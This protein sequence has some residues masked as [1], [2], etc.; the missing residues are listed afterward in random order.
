MVERGLLTP[1]QAEE[2]QKRGGDPAESTV[3]SLPAAPGAGAPGHLTPPTPATGRSDSGVLFSCPPCGKVY[4]LP[5]GN[6]ASPPVCPECRGALKPVQLGSLIVNAAPAPAAPEGQ[7]FGR[8]LLKRELG[9]GGMGVVYEAWDPVLGRPVALKMLSGSGGDLDA[10]AVERLLREA[11]AAAKLRHPAIVGIHDVGQAEGR[12]YF[13]MDL[14]DGTGLDAL[15]ARPDW[16]ETLPLRRRVEIVADVADALG[17]AHA[18]GIIHRDVKPSNILLDWRGTVMLLDF[19]L[20][21]DASV[22]TEALTRTGVL[23][24]TPHYMSPE[25]ASRSARAAGPGSDVFSLGVVFY[26]LLTAELPF[27]G[28][29]VQVLL[30]IVQGEPER[31]SKRDPAVPR[32]LETICLKCLEKDPAQRYPD[33]ETL[34]EDL[35][36]WLA[37]EPIAARPVGWGRRLWRRLTRAVPAPAQ[38]DVRRAEEEKSR[39]IEHARAQ[40]EAMKLLEQAR[41]ALDRATQYLYDREAGYEE[42]TRRVDAAQA[43]IEQ[44]LGKCG[45]L[46]LGH[47]LLGRAW[48]LKGLDDRAEGCWRE[49]LRLDPDFGPA[50]YQLGR[51]LVERAYTWPL[52][53]LPEERAAHASEAQRWA[54]EA[55]EEFQRALTLGSGF[56]D[57][58]LKLLAAAMVAFT[59][60]DRA[61][62]ARMCRSGITD[63]PGAEGREEFHWLLGVCTTGEERGRELDKA[64]E[65]RPKY[66]LARFFR[67]SHRW[68]SGD[69][70]GARVDFDETIRI[71]PHF[72]AAR[73]NRGFFLYRS[74]DAAGALRDLDEAVRLSPDSAVAWNNRGLAKS[75]LGDKAGAR[76]D[77]ESALRIKP[78]YAAALVNRAGC[79]R[80]D[81]DLDGAL[82]DAT[83]AI[84]SDPKCGP[85]WT[86]RGLAR[87]E[88]GDLTGALSDYEESIRLNPRSAI[89]WNNRGNVKSALRDWAGALADY[90]EA[91]KLNPKFHSAHA[92][93][94]EVL[95]KMGDPD[96]ALAAGER[97]LAI[98]PNHAFSFAVRGT[99]KARKGDV[100]GALADLDRALALDSVD[101]ETLLERALLRE[102]LGR[103][104]EGAADIRAALEAAKKGDW[105]RRKEA[106]AALGRMAE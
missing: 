106:E 12:H 99:A 72:Y 43:L 86:N 24:G 46:A 84:A 68:D 77:Y 82:A 7:P 100:E 102:R 85:A 101:P 70:A 29:E 92:N 79:R 6:P 62:A 67:A 50:H 55:E 39:A 37:G 49:A 5:G 34:A 103:K 52:T 51:L 64:I 66:A 87:Y 63:Y 98:N 89:A 65:I 61:G 28:D 31:P 36:H 8:Y 14:V 105:D 40:A 25:Q 23:L 94:G 15:L 33:G 53:H 35:R 97:G 19:G 81:G 45:E 96:G 2:A 76:A 22:A 13:T 21:H 80:E 9:R 73:N 10:T 78:H 47:Y 71:R 18:R 59:K 91:L 56:D 54:K 75:A 17:Y 69:T 44:A 48:L 1:A 95:L 38:E 90:A 104:A 58:P 30:G 42:L 26:R 60:E 41:P 93:T 88:R 74:G 11:R 16:K 32:D 57:A 83:A 20:A 4:S 3:D 27:A